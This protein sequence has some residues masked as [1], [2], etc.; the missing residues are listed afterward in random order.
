M[1]ASA[2]E[3]PHYHLPS[4]LPDTLNPLLL[5]DTAK[6]VALSAWRIANQ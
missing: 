5:E 6:L 1:F 3:H 4:D 2:G